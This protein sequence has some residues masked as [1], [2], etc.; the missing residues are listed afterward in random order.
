MES[1]RG[2]EPVFFPLDEELELLPGSLT[3][4]AYECLVRLGAW[5]PSFEQAAQQLAGM[6]KIKVSEAMSRR[7]TQGA[8]A[9]YEA[10]QRQEVERIEQELPLPPAGAVKVQ[11]SAD[12]AMVPL[13]GGEWTEVKTVAI[14][15]IGE[16]I[17][18]DGERVV[19]TEK[20]TYFSRRVEAQQFNWRAKFNLISTT[21]RLHSS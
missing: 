11:V 2:V 9:A 7:R 16:T 3:P 5:I 4:H 8:G 20:I 18:S 15:E 13:V 17:R 6:L 21:T 19:R 10:V 14:G 1:V 12:G